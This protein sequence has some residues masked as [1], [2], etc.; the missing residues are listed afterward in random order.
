MS[1]LD[2]TIRQTHISQSSEFVIISQ[3]FFLFLF[4][5]A[6]LFQAARWQVSETLCTKALC[7]VGGGSC[8]RVIDTGSSL[9]LWLCLRFLFF[10]G[11]LNGPSPLH[12]AGYCVRVS[13][14][15][16]RH[17]FHLC[18]YDSRPVSL[19]RCPI[20]LCL[21]ARWMFATLS[22]ILLW[23]GRKTDFYLHLLSAFLVMLVRHHDLLL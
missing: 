3:L 1:H 22:R 5:P 6:G 17:I 15:E 8:H 2:G 19:N 23:Q 16:P 18:V 14:P 4:L 12:G 20:H 21:S 13:L 10:M 11:L 7:N 9:P